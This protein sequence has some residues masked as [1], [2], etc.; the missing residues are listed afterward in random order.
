MKGEGLW[1]TV[2]VGSAAV[3][4]AVAVLGLVVGSAP[5]PSPEHLH[6]LKGMVLR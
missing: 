4:G 2:V 5:R 1:R 3:G 6:A